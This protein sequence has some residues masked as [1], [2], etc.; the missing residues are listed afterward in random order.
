M[1]ISMAV[2][3]NAL[4]N[5][6]KERF[7]IILEPLQAFIQLALLSFTPIDSKLNIYDN[8]LFIQIPGWKQSIM[9][10]YYSDSKNDLFYLF[11]VIKRFNK[12]Y[13]HLESV[14]NDKT[15]LFI[16][17]KQ[18][19]NKGIDNLLQTYKQ[20]DNPALLHTLNIYKDILNNSNNRVI[21]NENNIND[22]NKS[23][24]NLF[25]EESS[26]QQNRSQVSPTSSYSLS[27]Q[28]APSIAP[29][30]PP[31]IS[32]SQLP[33]IVQSS[34]IDID[35]VFINITRLYTEYDLLIIF[36]TLLLIQINP[37]NYIEYMEGLNKILE[38]INN[39]IKK[40]IVDNIV[41]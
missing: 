38:P 2:I 34:N 22:D 27:P 16:L 14:E 1:S 36:N 35:N 20:T 13:K 30:I 12:F 10:T 5:K 8:I 21:N 32:L 17:L 29:S 23:I 9:R 11:N 37:N 39:L 6:K 7:D 15:N 4:F 41:Y 25:N 31:S 19:S 3:H 24:S 26:I 40:W 28:T 18:L 33:S